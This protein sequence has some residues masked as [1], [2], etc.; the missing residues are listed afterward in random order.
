M[1]KVRKKFKY[2]D[3]YSHGG[4]H[5]PYDDL[6]MPSDNTSVRNLTGPFQ[7]IDFKKLEEQEAFLSPEGQNLQ[8][9]MDDITSVNLSAEG[10]G[11]VPPALATGA[12]N[13][14]NNP[15]LALAPSKVF[16]IPAGQVYKYGIKPVSNFLGRTGK[17]IARKVGEY[18]AA[19]AANKIKPGA[20]T[21]EALDA[22]NTYNKMWFE[23][24]ETR[25]K[26][27]QLF[28]SEYQVNRPMQRFGQSM[29]E[30]IDNQ[31]YLTSYPSLKGAE[32]A[33]YGMY[34]PVNYA[35]GTVRRPV[36]DASNAGQSS[37]PV[38]Y[39]MENKLLGNPLED[40]NAMKALHG[41]M[42][43]YA[44]Q[45][46]VTRTVQDPTNRMY[47]GIHEGLHGITNRGFYN[48]GDDAYQ[49]LASKLRKPFKKKGLKLNEEGKIIDYR[50]GNMDADKMYDNYIL[51]PQEIYAR[52]QEIRHHAMMTPSQK[53]ITGEE[54]KDL[55]TDSKGNYLP[56]IGVHVRNLIDKS[57][58]FK[59]L[60]ELV[61]YLPAATGVAA[62]GYGLSQQNENNMKQY[63]Y[64]GR[65]GMP[66][67]GDGGLF[68]SIFGKKFKDSGFGKGIRDLG[69]GIATMGAAPLEAMLG[70]D[71]GIDEKFGYK[72]KFGET[73]GNIG[74]TVGS[75]VGS[76]A[77]AAL[78]V[79]APGLG[80]AVQMGGQ[81]IG[82]GLEGAGVTQDISTDAQ[83]MIGSQLGQLGTMFASGNPSGMFGDMAQNMS[84]T[85]G[86]QQL[87]GIF[88][89][90][91]GMNYKYKEGGMAEQA[92]IEAE[93]GEL[94]LTQGGQPQSMN[95][96]AGLN[97]LGSGAYEI[98]GDQS[99]SKGG[100]PVSLPT[101]ETVIVTNEKG[102]SARVKALYKKIAEANKK[103]KSTDFIEAQQGELEARNA[104]A[105]VQE[106]IEAQQ[107]DNNN[108]TNVA[109][110]GGRYMKPK[111]QTGMFNFNFPTTGPYSTASGALMTGGT[112]LPGMPQGIG[113]FDMQVGQLNEDTMQMDM[114][115]Q[116]NN[117]QTMSLFG[118]QPPMPQD[119]IV[120]SPISTGDNQ[121][122][123]GNY[124]PATDVFSDATNTTTN[125]T[126]TNN[127]N[128]NTNNTGNG[129]KFGLG[130]IL[131]YASSIYN[132]IGGIAGIIN[133]PE[134]LDA[135]QYQITDRMKANRIDPNAMMAPQKQI[136]ATFMNQTQDPR[137]KA[138]FAASL[139]PQ[140]ASQFARTEYLNRQLENEA[141]RYNLG[142]DRYN[143]N[144][145]ARVD[146]LN[147]GIQAM[148]YQMLQQ[149][150]GQ[151]A[152]TYL[153]M[154]RNNLLRDLAN[155]ARFTEGNFNLNLGNAY[156]TR[157]GKIKK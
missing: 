31:G 56:E 59:D 138:A 67:Y 87:S 45:N 89:K 112:M 110:Y 57:K 81:M 144:M 74:E 69:V 104:Q 13:P 34:N 16:T 86:I 49:T 65:Y 82:S 109:K 92:D 135:S 54:L 46:F 108:K 130:N 131:P 72:T 96:K 63:N 129:N 151:A 77:P 143:K 84:N 40:F 25:R 157:P 80:T 145:Q 88:M 38:M 62:T 55:L 156:G 44:G 83:S 32:D 105:Q 50:T 118:T 39:H 10:Q 113:T 137:R 120:T 126:N 75:A 103:R 114:F 17:D 2:K 119:Q 7:E 128:T 33:M 149:G 150:L 139:A 58:S 140:T 79:V 29:R 66:N 121:I 64:G 28:G 26:I 117:P 102:R 107:K 60:A 70:T 73:V 71:F 85:Q 132:T 36:V 22:A 100:V 142:I 90:H 9:E 116:F 6:T 27:S 153:A 148:P 15:A 154:D 115:P 125:N 4:V 14:D 11:F 101:G 43:V 122:D 48:L 20:V 93:S 18:E 106:E 47:T 136:A 98:K 127:T 99:H 5:S 19:L 23:A 68:K 155:T 141:Q 61:N 147:M 134:G 41:D 152:N 97:N 37:V 21:D 146:Q 133:P 76:F 8:D 51:D 94:L 35:R 24:P 53:N 111:A 30:S 123:L 95:P 52:V 91:G 12:V 3:K 42:N 124:T 1:A 78:N